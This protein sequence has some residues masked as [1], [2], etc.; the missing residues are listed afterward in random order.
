MSSIDGKVTKV[1]EW[2]RKSSN[3]ETGEGLLQRKRV[4]YFCGEDIKD[5]LMSDTFKRKGL[6]P[7]DFGDKEIDEIGSEMMRQRLIF[8]GVITNLD[9][10]DLEEL[11]TVEPHR[12]Q[13]FIDEPEEVYVWIMP[14][15][16]AELYM[17]CAGMLFVVL[18]MCMIKIWPLWL[19]IGVWWVS[20]IMLICMTSLIAIRLVLAGLFSMVGF[21]GIWLLPNLLN[22][23]IDF[24]DAFSPLFGRGINLRQYQQEQLKRLAARRRRRGGD[25]GK[26]E[27]GEEVSD[28]KEDKERTDEM[29]SQDDTFRIGMTNLAVIFIIGIVLCNYFGLFMPDNI[30]DF[31]VSQVE[32]W[33]EYPGLAPPEFDADVHAAEEAAKHARPGAGVKLEDLL[34]E[35]D[36]ED[37]DMEGEYVPD[38]ILD[39]VDDDEGEFD[40]LDLPD[41]PEDDEEEE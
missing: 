14:P 25:M 38:P 17:K 33:K 39:R 32:L 31:V 27:P 15:S 7:K 10:T 13:V 21:K 41:V 34:K 1:A 12:R 24:L 30:P 8:R 37:T 18:F 26:E 23:D 5:A 6:L 28:E 2:L 29:L 40:D 4:D 36:E 20:L 11:D 3:M 22:D 9:T 16:R 35:D 19:K